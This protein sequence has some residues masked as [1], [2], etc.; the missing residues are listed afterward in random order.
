MDIGMETERLIIDSI[1]ETDKRDYFDNISHDKKV[2]ETFMCRY[3]ETYEDFDF[4][5]YLGRE[6]MYAIRL[7]DTGKLIGV[8]LCFDEAF[9]KCE[10]GYGL[11]SPYWGH[12][13]VLKKR[14]ST[15]SLLPSLMETRLQS[16]LWRSVG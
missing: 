9:G 15:R 10:I 2:L 14:D 5:T 6:D 3:A 11:G 4:S 13:Y 16:M 7:K 12:G 8:I 1:R